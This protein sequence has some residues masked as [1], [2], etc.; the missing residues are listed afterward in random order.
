MILGENEHAISEILSF[1]AFY[2]RCILGISCVL[3][4]KNSQS[5][6]DVVI[7]IDYNSGTVPHVRSISRPQKS[8]TCGLYPAFLWC[9]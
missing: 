9:I 1:C 4:V 7:N 6:V 5:Y 8:L 3:A 2:T